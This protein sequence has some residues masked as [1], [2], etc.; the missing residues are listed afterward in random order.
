M[1]A[2]VTFSLPVVLHSG[3]GAVSGALELLA[4]FGSRRALLV[5]DPG[6]AA[7]GPGASLERRLRDSGRVVATYREVEQN[8]GLGSVAD[9]AA[10]FSEHGCDGN[11]AIGG[12]SGIDTAKVAGV[13]ATHGGAAGHYEGVEQVPGPGPPL[14]CVPTT[15]GTGAEVTRNAVITDPGRRCKFSL[16]SRHLWPTAAIL[17]AELLIEIP[18]PIAATTALDAL[19][20]AVEAFTNR[21]DHGVADACSRE[22]MRLI[23]GH[24]RRAV[25]R[26]QVEDLGALLSASA[27]AGI[28]LDWCGL[29]LV[30][31]LSVPLGGLFGI[32]HGLANAVLLPFVTE[33]NSCA[34]PNR[35][36]EVATLL[37]G[38]RAQAEDCARLIREL[39]GDLGIPGSLG[40]LGV[41]LDDLAHLLHYT[42]RS[43]NIPL[44]PRAPTRDEVI[45]I[46]RRAVQ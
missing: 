14:V 15:C 12:G 22:A 37:A 2:A 21:A 36:A 5:I 35:Y 19:T 40:P 20:H 23:A 3:P 32:P 29:G 13:I 11:L 33:Y 6:F 31:A 16:R 9:C 4:S 27:L 34:A 25:G 28:S 39:N 8:P 26:R 44:N 30:H 24:A 46:L 43:R 10:A 17:D 45:E 18:R 41:T 7:T 42:F 1:T 38:R